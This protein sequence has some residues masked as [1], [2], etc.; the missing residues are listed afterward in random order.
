MEAIDRKFKI[1]AVCTEHGHVYTEE[2]SVL[3]C[4]KDATLPAVLRC[5][6]DI[7]RQMGADARQLLGYQ[8]LIE[9][10][11]RWQAEHGQQVKIPDVDLGPAGDA[12]V[13]RNEEV[14]PL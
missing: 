4:A 10:V 14:R 12:I 1:T 2:N 7:C 9:R 5:A 13:A 3:F 6:R 8:L 11:E